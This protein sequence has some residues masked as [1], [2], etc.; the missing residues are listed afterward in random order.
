MPPSDSRDWT[1]ND[2]RRDKPAEV[3]AL[4]DRFLAAVRACGPLEVQPLERQIVLHGRRRVFASIRLTAQGLPGH[5]NLARRVRT[6]ASR[7]SSR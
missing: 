5:L 1:V 3:V 6:R 7:P 2:H 4:V